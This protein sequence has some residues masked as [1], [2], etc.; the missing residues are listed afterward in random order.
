VLDMFADLDLDRELAQ[1]GVVLHV[2]A[3][4]ES[5]VTVA[6]ETPG[7]EWLEKSGRVHAT[8]EDGLA[9]ASV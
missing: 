1:Q 3:L 4:P 7:Y 6:R 5:A 9:A 2:A 8:V